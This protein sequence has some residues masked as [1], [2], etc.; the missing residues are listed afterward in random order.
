MAEGN[1]G[2]SMAVPFS[3]FTSEEQRAAVHLLW[4][5]EIKSA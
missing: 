1:E 3:D 5:E 4:A 2:R